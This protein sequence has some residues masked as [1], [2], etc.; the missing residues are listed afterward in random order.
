MYNGCGRIL[1]V[2]TKPDEYYG[3][4]TGYILGE[5]RRKWLVKTANNL[6]LL[7]TRPTFTFPI[8]EETNHKAYRW[9]F[10]EN[11]SYKGFKFFVEEKY[12]IQMLITKQND[13]T[14]LT[15]L[16]SRYVEDM[17]TIQ[18]GTSVVEMNGTLCS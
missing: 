15:Y 14:F 11:Y 18:D 10:L 12:L 6:E 1:I 16:M 8:D 17:T 3:G 9:V 4:T 5:K 2:I 7:V 13:C